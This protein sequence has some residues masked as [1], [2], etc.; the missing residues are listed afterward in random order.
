MTNEEVQ[1]SPMPTEQPRSVASETEAL[2]RPAPRESGKDELSRLLRYAEKLIGMLGDVEYYAREER[3]AIR[4]RPQKGTLE[5]EQKLDPKNLVAEVKKLDV[6]VMPPSVSVDGGKIIIKMG[7]T[8]WQAPANNAQAIQ[9]ELDE[10]NDLTFRAACRSL[11]PTIAKLRLLCH[12][13]G[14]LTAHDRLETMGDV[15]RIKERGRQ[16]RAR[17]ERERELAAEDDD[18]YAR[19]AKAGRCDSE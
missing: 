17:R 3:T 18:E 13:E 8:T 14:V 15:S 7:E 4:D 9:I 6:S 1:G 11:A 16:D 12:K 5:G 10:A 19:T 2:S